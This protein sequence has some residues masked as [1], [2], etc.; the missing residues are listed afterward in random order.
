MLYEVWV[1]RYTFRQLIYADLCIKH[2]KT[3]NV[4]LMAMELKFRHRR[5]ETQCPRCN[6]LLTTPVFIFEVPECV[7]RLRSFK[8]LS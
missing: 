8:T 3:L 1:L 2:F 6:Q 5:C 4:V 7:L